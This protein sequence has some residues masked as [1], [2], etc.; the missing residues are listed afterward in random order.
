M[1]YVKQWA[2]INTEEHGICLR[3]VVQDF[4][5][6]LLKLDKRVLQ[7]LLV[8]IAVAFEWVCTKAENETPK[9]PWERR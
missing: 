2:I 6:I 1:K 3:F 5:A 7:D 8:H 4:D 9:M